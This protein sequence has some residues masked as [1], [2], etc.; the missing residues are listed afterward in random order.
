MSPIL[1]I[2]FLVTLLCVMGAIDGVLFQQLLFVVAAV[3]RS[4]YSNSNSFR[5]VELLREA[6]VRSEDG[7]SLR[8]R[9]DRSAA[10]L[11][12]ATQRARRPGRCSTY[13]ARQGSF[14]LITMMLVSR[15]WRRA[16]E[17]L[18]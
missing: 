10:E 5:G 1:P 12:A 4:R 6:P 11:I 9:K 15:W 16:R 14:P 7:G 8:H 2:S 17:T 18:L 3:C 13:G